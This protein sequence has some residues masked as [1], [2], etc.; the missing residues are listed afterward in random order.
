MDESEIE[1]LEDYLKYVF[2][3][4]EDTIKKRKENPMAQIKMFF[5]GQSDVA[6][7]L[8]PSIARGQKTECDVNTKLQK[9]R[10]YITKAKN[11]YPKV[12]SN[13]LLPID[14]LAKLQHYGIPTRLLDVTSNPLVALYFAC[15]DN[16]NKDGAVYIFKKE[17]EDIDNFPIVQGIA[18]SYKFAGTNMDCL[19]D[20]CKMV[21]DQPYSIEQ[22][23]FVENSYPSDAEKNKW[24]N[25]CCEKPFFVYGKNISERQS[26]QHG[27]YILFHND[28]EKSEEF[29]FYFTR[30]I[31]PMED[32]N[33]CI[34]KKI[35][36]P[37]TLK[38]QIINKLDILGINEMFLFPENVDLLQKNL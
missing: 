4:Y 29:G 34:V 12:F 10:N 1:T 9:E 31:S 11:Y 13:D 2:T 37:S 21:M 15:N 5:R 25:L 27:S 14:L 3:S 33:E 28:I 18:E 17:E 35:I 16:H 23:Y 32:S 20:F 24:I 36:I 8:H 38:Q 6:F 26:R 19:D 22:K 7:K 30:I